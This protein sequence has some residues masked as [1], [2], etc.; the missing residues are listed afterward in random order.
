MSTPRDDETLDKL[1]AGLSILQKRRGHRAASD[2]TLLAWCAGRA[3][4]DAERVLDLGTGKGTVALLLAAR[5][6][7]CRIIGV[8]AEPASFDLAR[9]NASLNG[10]ES[11]FSPRFG[12]LRLGS[13]LADEA[14]FDLITGAPP[15]M[16][17]GSG[18]VPRDETRAAGRFELR[19]GVADYADTAARHLAISGRA[20]LLMD[21]SEASFERSL[22][23]F[24]DSGLGL[25]RILVVLPRP[26]RP[27]TYRV[28]VLTRAIGTDRPASE[29][30]CMRDAEGDA[31]SKDYQTARLEMGL[32]V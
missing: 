2:D 14:P 29:T 13:I 10:L 26:G 20:V 24:S 25:A 22:R 3:V 18:V 6:P 7:T 5:L 16:P 11:R 21:G 12:D 4:P 19:G 15:F 1:T 30:L 27:P 8:E 32:V 17:L 28:F 23:A 9:R 31:F